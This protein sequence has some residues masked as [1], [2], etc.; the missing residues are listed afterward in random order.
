MF[1]NNQEQ[2][3]NN[4]IVNSDP[5]K[6]FRRKSTFKNYQKFNRLSTMLANP[7]NETNFQEKINQM[8][9]DS[10]LPMNF[11]LLLE[12][13]NSKGKM[14]ES[15]QVI[16]DMNKLMNRFNNIEKFESAL[17]ST[18]SDKKRKVNFTNIYNN[19]LNNF[20]GT[21]PN[22]SVDNLEQSHF[23]EDNQFIKFPHDKIDLDIAL[24]NFNRMLTLSKISIDE[25]KN[26]KEELV[27]D[28][29]LSKK[30][31][32]TD[33]EIDK[34]KANKQKFNNVKAR[35]SFI[36]R[37]NLDLLC[38]KNNFNYQVMVDNYLPQIS[39]NRNEENILNIKKNQ[40]KM[41]RKSMDFNDK[42]YQYNIDDNTDCNTN[43][44]RNTSFLSLNKKR[45]PVNNSYNS[46]N[47]NM[48]G[49]IVNSKVKT[50]SFANVKY[51]SKNST[52]N[53]KESSIFYN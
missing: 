33:F 23:S 42:R 17:L 10:F 48:R 18:T 39:T 11:E 2:N 32:V 35:L 8:N 38:K 6:A 44:K 20:V 51:Q 40:G 13:L 45:I 52:T 50:Y 4:N 27:Y 53:N 43:N 36:E 41:N 46:K 21:S 26:N 19:N 3:S 24:K 1:N 12:F 14:R 49:S 22:Q 31:S 25:K 28:I 29:G 16:K 47:N 37:V 5:S 30:N 9:K 7:Q 34:T 15:E